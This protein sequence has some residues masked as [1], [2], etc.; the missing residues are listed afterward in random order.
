MSQLV[1]APTNP[2][3]RLA[4]SV[5]GQTARAA[6]VAGRIFAAALAVA[7]AFEQGYDGTQAFTSMLAILVLATVLVRRDSA[8]ADWLA[9]LGAGVAFFGGVV[10][11]HLGP[12]LGMRAMGLVAFSGGAAFAYRSGRDVMLPAVAVIGSVFLTGAL[13]FTVVFLFE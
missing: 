4:L 7:V 10:L 6:S 5:P 11:A 1:P 13:Q 2:L 8:I 12:G 9:A 3:S